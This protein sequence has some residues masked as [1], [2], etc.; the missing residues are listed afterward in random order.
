MLRVTRREWLAVSGLAL[1]S[2]CGPKKG[3]GY[4]GYALIATSGDNS[5]AV[6]DLTA[7]K[8]LR[9]IQLNASP[10]AV[11]PG[12]PGGRIYVLTPSTGSVHVLTSELARIATH[13][14]ADQLSAIRVAADGKRLVAISAKSHELIEADAISLKVRRRRKL[15]GEPLNIDVAQTLPYVAVTTAGDPGTVELFHLDNGQHWRTQMPGRVGDVRFRADGQLLLAANFHDCSLTVLNVPTLELVADLPLAMQP[16]NLCFN[17]DQGQLFV[18]GEGMDGIAIVFP[19]NTLVDQ[20]VLAGRDPGVMASSGPSPAYLFVASNN[21]S[22]VCVLNIYSRKVIGIV[23]AGSQPTYIT[24]T[25]DNQYALVLDEQA[26][27]MAVIHIPAI[28]NTEDA[29]HN[30]RRKA[31][32]SLFTMIPVGERP[33][34]AAVVPG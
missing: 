9:P 20:T 4:A 2:A 8:L 12:G 27:Q 21:G 6:V 32:A 29:G 34:Q 14:L 7:F 11:V 24:I 16:Q 19:Y 26:G 23:D 17:S 1:S 10:S 28:Q 25:P 33:V 5:V 30:F 13:R 22:D 15:Q 3:T 31:G 18:T